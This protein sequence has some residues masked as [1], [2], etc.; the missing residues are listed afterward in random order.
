MDNNQ[1]LDNRESFHNM[2]KPAEDI[3][4]ADSNNDYSTEPV[5]VPT[6]LELGIEDPIKRER[7]RKF[8]CGNSCSLDSGI[9]RVVF[10]ALGIAE[11]GRGVK[12]PTPL[13]K[14]LQIGHL[15]LW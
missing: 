14:Y 11:G 10:E 15:H 12:P 7:L 8:S 5:F 9:A 1:G 6:E 4:P 2:G 3:E 13:L